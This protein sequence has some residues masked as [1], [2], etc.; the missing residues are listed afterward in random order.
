MRQTIN[1]LLCFC[2]VALLYSCANI[3]KLKHEK[4]TTSTKVESTE[5]KE[6]ATA[7]EATEIYKQK[8]S[9]SN[10][11]GTTETGNE[12]YVD[13]E[14]DSTGN[15]NPVEIQKTDSGYIVKPGGRKIKS[16]NLKEKKTSENKQVV[17]LSE[18]T[19]Q[20]TVKA[21]SGSLYENKQIQVGNT[22]EESLTEVKKRRI[23]TGVIILVVVLTVIGYVLYKYDRKLGIAK[24]F[25]NNEDN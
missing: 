13:F 15:K 10:V 16:L 21:D 4:K 8:D 17:D 24:R 5:T 1:L 14:N 18:I 20:N 12:F 2:C 11:T 7:V 22:E 23:A 25:I 9:S 6:V 3:N 19:Q